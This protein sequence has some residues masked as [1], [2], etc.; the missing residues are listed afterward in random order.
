ML[1]AIKYILLSVYLGM[2]AC[3]SAPPLEKRSHEPEVVSIAYLK[4]L[5]PGVPRKIK[6]E[7]S[8]EGRVIANDEYNN[9]YRSIVIQDGTGGI[10]IKLDAPDL[11]LN[12]Y[13]IIEGKQV[14]IFGYGEKI[15]INCH[16]LAVGE[17]GGPIQLGS[18]SENSAYE[19]G[20]IPQHRIPY[21]VEHLEGMAAEPIPIPFTIAHLH[22]SQ[23]DTWRY[24]NCL[25]VLPGVQFVNYDA[26]TTWAEGE[27]GA[28]NRILTDMHG[29]T[30]DVRTSVFAEFAGYL[31]PT[32]SGTIRGI[33]GWFNGKPQL[34]VYDYRDADMNGERFLLH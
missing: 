33:L 31:L 25:V 14:Q 1:R 24:V 5:Y 32:G 34:T 27:T 23:F 9:F 30:L 3:D 6:R 20:Y 13:K 17:Y 10:E 29:N 26:G 15:R 21:V 4:S 7:I 8:I 28:T 22:S 12:Y 19:T 11:Y 2:S 18:V 16:G